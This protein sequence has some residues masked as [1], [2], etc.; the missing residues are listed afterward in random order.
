MKKTLLTLAL[1]LAAIGLATPQAQAIQITGSITFSG[2]AIANTLDIN[3]ATQVTTWDNPVVQSRSGTVYTAA[4]VGLPVAIASPWTFA[5]GAVA[6]FWVVAG[7]FS[8]DLISSSVT[9]QGSGGILVTGQGTLKATGFED[10]PGVWRFTSQ[11]PAGDRNEFSFSAANE[12]QPV[13]EGGSAVAMLG[14]GLLGLA[15]A[16]KKLVKTA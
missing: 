2:G 10:T 16:R 6:N 15:A 3:T 1:G 5:S 11:N 7:G 13:P 9:T 14:M 4:L 8:F 12:A